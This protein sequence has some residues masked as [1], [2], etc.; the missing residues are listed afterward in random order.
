MLLLAQ[1]SDQDKR[2]AVRRWS[3]ANKLPGELG[4]SPPLSH[5]GGM[6]QGHARANYRDRSHSEN[7]DDE[8]HENEAR[9]YHD[10]DCDTDPADESGPGEYEAGLGV[11]GEP[12]EISETRVLAKYIACMR[13]WYNLS[14]RERW[15]HFCAEV[16]HHFCCRCHW[17]NCYLA[18][19]A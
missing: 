16:R 8:A 6:Y 11:A 19:S 1:L 5:S 17:P 12:F 4:G 3:T 10:G 18:P 9:S 13:D 7:D 2:E 15:D 14:G